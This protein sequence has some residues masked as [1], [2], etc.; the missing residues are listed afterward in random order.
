VKFNG[1][2]KVYWNVS[3]VSGCTVTPSNGSAWVIAGTAGNSWTSSPGS[4]G[5]ASAAITQRTTFTLSCAALDTSSI[6]E[7]VTVNIA[8]VFQEK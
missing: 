3:N 8:P 1:T 4:A 2:T 7:T 6:H 5:Q